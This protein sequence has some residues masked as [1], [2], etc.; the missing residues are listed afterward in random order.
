MA[1]LGLLLGSKWGDMKAMRHESF[2]D[3]ITAILAKRNII[4]ATEAAAL[5]KSFKES[6][7]PYFDEFLLDEGLVEK[8]DLLEALA[9]YYQVP[10]FDVV[11]YFF[12]HELVRMF[13]QD[14]LIRNGIIPI[15]Q[16]E[17]I[18]VVVAS[19]PS[20]P[21]L[22]PRIGNYVSYDVQFRVGIRSDIVD[23]IEEF[24]QRSLTEV[25]YD[26]ELD[27]QREMHETEIRKARELED[28]A[29]EEIDKN[30]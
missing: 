23:A 17:N 5:R 29:I 26:R 6:A 10:A 28:I 21:D 12:D 19:D 20:N 14:F 1:L 24:Y 7:K 3:G 16:D 15:E 9:E 18:L 4:K 27:E 2:I 22:L 11:G 13:P 30:E 8:D 25:D